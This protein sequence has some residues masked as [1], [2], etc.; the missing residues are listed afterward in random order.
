MIV[1][2]TYYAEK[3]IWLE[4]YANALHP[5]LPYYPEGATLSDCVRVAGDRED[6][7][8]TKG[9]VA[10]LLQVLTKPIPEELTNVAEK[11][12]KLPFQLEAERIPRITIGWSDG[13]EKRQLATVTDGSPYAITLHRRNDWPAGTSPA[14]IH[15]AYVDVVYAAFFECLLMEAWRGETV[16][17]CTETQKKL[18][19][20]TVLY[21]Y[22][23]QIQLGPTF[24]GVA[25]IRHELGYNIDDLKDC[26]RAI[27]EMAHV[28]KAFVTGWEF[29]KLDSPPSE[30]PLLKRR[31]GKG[32][33]YLVRNPKRLF[34]SRFELLELWCLSFLNYKKTSRD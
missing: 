15:L 31:D 34:A 26:R 4:K 6:D 23:E 9:H 33:Q 30:H 7:I 12:I 27:K 19:G 14:S 2:R 8:L 24:P 17:W 13:A 10:H 28:L 21:D 1:R 20:F 32:N 25:E 18:F 11:E 16:F 29:E 22:I 5:R 3:F